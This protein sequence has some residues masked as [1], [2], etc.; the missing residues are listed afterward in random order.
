MTNPINSF[1][2]KLS[3]I[4]HVSGRFESHH[5]LGL[6]QMELSMPEGIEQA[7]Q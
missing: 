7:L 4:A 1:S 6:Q 5:R 2:Q 3:K